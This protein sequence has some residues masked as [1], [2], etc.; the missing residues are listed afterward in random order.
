VKSCDISGQLFGR[1]KVLKRHGRKHG[2]TTWVCVCSCGN[3]C[4]KI[5]THLVNGLSRSCGCL[6][7]EVASRSGKANTTHGNAKHG[8]GIKPSKTYRTWRAMKVRCLNA[9]HTHYDRYGG[10]GI[11]VCARW[12][13]SF[14]NFLADM[15]ERP[16]G[17]SLNNDGNYEPSNCRWASAREQGQNRCARKRRTIA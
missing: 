10:R 16:D 14:E 12:L 11:S 4:V 6:R 13:N 9:N 3:K 1:L 17:L 8:L 15:G 5:A 2:H 7:S